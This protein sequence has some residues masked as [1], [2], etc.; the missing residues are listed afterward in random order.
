MSTAP[1]R[2]RT[3]PP[4]AAVRRMQA[5]PYFAQKM[6]IATIA[7]LFRVGERTV[8]EWAAHPDVRKALGEVGDAVV[9]ATK[10]QATELVE[11]AWR[12]LGDVMR[13]GEDERTRVEA[14]KLVLDRTGHGPTSKQEVSGP[15]GTPIEIVA[16]EHARIVDLARG[17]G[18]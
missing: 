3:P 4:S 15:Q 5:V 1:K 16:A 7:A 14:A 8:K 12:T 9:E 10:V 11:L 17:S 18:E 6:P 13:S 2:P